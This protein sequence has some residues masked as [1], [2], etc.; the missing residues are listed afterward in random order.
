MS[1][2]FKDFPKVKHTDQVLTDITKRVRFVDTIAS[3]PKVFL[4]YTIKEEESP[5]E[6]S[7]YYYGSVDFVWVIYLANNIIDP[8]KDWPMND[9]NFYA[10]M[11]EKYKTLSGETEDFAVVAWTQDTT[12]DD[13]VL[14]YAHVDDAELRISPDSYS[15][16]NQ[17][18]DSFIAGDWYAVRVYDAEYEA[19][20]DKR[21]IQVIDKKY[22]GQV[23]DEL[24]TLMNE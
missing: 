10:Y 4:P 12:I 15:L 5:E 3:D 16:S 2:Y 20:E 1:R 22:I 13:N 11:A 21:V 6:L 24:R 8:Y 14:Y 7:Y 19:N 18:D 9:R 23:A 17:L